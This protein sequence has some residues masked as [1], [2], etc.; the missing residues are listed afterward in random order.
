LIDEAIAVFKTALKH[1][2]ESALLYD[3]LAEAY[4]KQKQTAMAIK[5]YQKSLELMPYNQ[6]AEEMLKFIKSKN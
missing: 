3:N 5:N 4:L 2:P 6:N 1:F